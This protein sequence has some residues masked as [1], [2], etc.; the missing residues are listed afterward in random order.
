MQLAGGKSGEWRLRGVKRLDYSSTATVAKKQEEVAL[1]VTT[2]DTST[3][4]TVVWSFCH[5]YIWLGGSAKTVSLASV[6]RTIYQ[7]YKNDDNN[8][9]ANLFDD[10]K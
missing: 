4:P 9:K 6:F 3:N 10:T 7:Q 1:K 5:R 8:A 2:V